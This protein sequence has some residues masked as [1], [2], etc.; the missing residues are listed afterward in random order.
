MYDLLYE[1][2]LPL[3]LEDV[4][5][6][7]QNLIP[8]VPAICIVMGD[9]KRTLSGAP[10]RTDNEFTIYLMV[11]HGGVRDNQLNYR[12]CNERA[13]AI[14][15]LLHTDKTMGDNVIHGYVTGMEPGYQEKKTLM[16]VTRITW[17]GLTKTLT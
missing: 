8:R 5:E 15:T 2:R 1:N 9:Y 17:Q 6:G 7:D 13:E 10:F 12:E 16:Y 4:W 3:V 14:M 11:Y